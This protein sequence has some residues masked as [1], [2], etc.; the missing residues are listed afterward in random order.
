LRSHLPKTERHS[1]FGEI[2]TDNEEQPISLIYAWVF[3]TDREEGLV[4]VSVGTL[5]D[6]NP[7]NNFLDR[8][9]VIRFN[10]EGKLTGA[11]HSYMAG[12]NLLVVGKN[13][14]FVLGL[15]N[16][17]LKEPNLIGELTEM[18]SLSARRTGGE[19]RATEA[20]STG[21]RSAAF[22]AAAASV[23][24]DASA[25]SKVSGKT[26]AAAARMAALRNRGSLPR[27]FP[28]A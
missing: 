28:F 6:G 16:T 23:A 1:E 5:V 11:M 22:Q 15:S 3:V 26:P 21:E 18:S 10:P 12:T 14:L 4:M 13:G 8:E 9:K 7:D 24:P 27:L 20:F 19:G 2:Y 17:E 25:K